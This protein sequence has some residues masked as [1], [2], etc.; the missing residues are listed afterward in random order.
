VP[1]QKVLI[2]GQ[3]RDANHSGEFQ[4]MNP[5]TRQ[6]LPEKYP[7][8][9]WDDC[10]TCLAAAT[11]AATALRS[12]PAERIAGFLERFAERCEGR[13]A[14]LVETANAET[15]L[16][17][18]P[19]LA[20]VELPRTTS[21]LRQA[22][23]AAREGS[24]S[25]AT[26]DTQS[27]IRS[28]YAAL[29]PVCVFGPNN[30]PFA[31]G[32]ISG[33]DF[34]AAIAAGNPVIAKANSSHPGT[35]R[36]LAEEAQAAA[37][38]TEMPPGTVQLLYR[39]KHDDGRRLVAD[40][41]V[42]AVGYTGSRNAG[43]NLKAAADAAGKPIYLE[44]SSINPVVILPG[45]LEERSQQIAEEFTTS[46]LM[47]TGQFCTNPGLVVVMQGDPS[48][49]FVKTVGQRFEEAPVGTLLSESVQSNLAVSHREL[50]DGGAEPV[51]KSSAPLDDQAIR[52]PNTLLRVS[53]SRFLQNPNALQVEAFGNSSLVVVVNDLDQACAVIDQL[54]GNLTG[55]VY[56]SSTGQDDTAYDRI[57]SHLR[58]RVG[59]L[60]NDKMPTGV[61]VSP[62][63]NHGGP[64]PA[65]G[66]P[67]FTAVG[68]PASMPRFAMLQCYD[69][70]RPHRLPPALQDK[71]PNGSMWR[72]IDGTWTQ[73]N[74]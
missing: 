72:L 44:L 62:A 39:L 56:S 11:E 6:P 65:T 71:N 59:R 10:D 35:T 22:A 38:E 18:S 23:S 26:I 8:S 41:R 21:Q 74:I 33:G 49:D 50:L 29:G 13:A 60:I 48:E 31:F 2:A 73:G 9:T 64:F 37:Q 16:P 7:V 1:L 30:F 66:H 36:V 14:E 52:H 45:A 68:I 15:A 32:S 70:V 20:D 19:R 40:P 63:M 25:H 57:A 24:W 4:A 58:Q 5:T 51:T 67:G 28:L 43:L 27:G 53:G 34:A 42:G 47:G 3:W 46:C 12:L 69:N 61:A 55:C 17:K 54:E